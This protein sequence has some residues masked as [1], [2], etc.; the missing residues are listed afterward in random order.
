MA[1]IV[2]REGFDKTTT[3]GHIFNTV[4]GTVSIGAFGRNST[5]GLRLA[6]NGSF[7]KKTLPSTLSTI[8]AGFSLKL[9]ALPSAADIWVLT[10]LL[11]A[12]N[13]QIRIVIRSDGTLAVQRTAGTGVTIA[14]VNLGVL[15]S[16]AMLV[17]VHYHISWKVVVHDTTG[18]VIVWVNEVEK[19]NLTNQDTRGFSGSALV[20]EVAFYNQN[21]IDSPVGNHDIDD[22]VVRDDAQVLDLQV[23]EDLP[24]GTGSTDQWSATGA[25]STR[26]AVDE[27]PPDDDTS[28]ASETTNG[29]KSIWTYPA[30]PTTATIVALGGSPRAKKTDAGTATFCSVF[31]DAA[32]PSDH[33]GPTLAP[34]NSSYE[35]HDNTWMVNPATSNP[36][37]PSEVNDAGSGLGVKRVS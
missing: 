22:F 35:Y 5:N 25:A 27:T 23:R 6:T 2:V 30:I 1:G 33:D 37:T 13:P 12:G 7:V 20:S 24:T 29:E 19:L 26:E 3:P 28:Y 17:G 18:E 10:V 21:I 9:S 15:S 31:R 16:F 14:G 34:S 4:S 11:D 8:W 36:F 32:G